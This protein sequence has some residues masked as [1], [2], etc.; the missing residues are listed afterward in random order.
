MEKTPFNGA[1]LGDRCRPPDRAEAALD[2]GGF[3]RKRLDARLFDPAITD[4]WWTGEAL[5]EHYIEALPLAK[6]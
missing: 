1:V 3:G 4:G 5:P 6:E 2:R